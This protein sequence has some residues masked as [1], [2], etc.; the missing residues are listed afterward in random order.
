M[1]TDL[2]VSFVC[3]LCSLRMVDA[4]HRSYISY[5]NITAHRHAPEPTFNHYRTVSHDLD[6]TCRRAHVSS[7]VTRRG[8]TRACRTCVI[9]H[10]ALPC[11]RGL[12]FARKH[13]SSLRALPPY[14][15]RSQRMHC[16]S[17]PEE[18]PHGELTESATRAAARA[19]LASHHMRAPRPSP[20]LAIGPLSFFLF[21]S[22]PAAPSALPSAQFQLPP[23][24][25]A[26]GYLRA[27][28]LLVG[29][30]GWRVRPPPP[31]LYPP[32]YIHLAPS[33]SCRSSPACHPR[34]A[35]LPSH[36]GAGNDVP[37]LS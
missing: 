3:I 29:T 20:S 16:D 7:H 21:C 27:P 26:I 32:L 14:C 33:P 30:A 12:A 4:R 22:T 28:C 8:H 9:C 18:S 25:N 34:S 35:L 23:S 5:S 24:A 1:E 17:E 2:N 10:V 6:K 15:T 19:T 36:C 11:P 13:A 37:S 31:P